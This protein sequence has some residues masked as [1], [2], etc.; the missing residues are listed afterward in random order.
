MKSRVDRCR[1]VLR[2]S[3]SLLLL[4]QRR[5][6]CCRGVCVSDGYVVA[7][8]VACLPFCLGC[9]GM[10]W[11]GGF[12]SDFQ[13]ESIRKPKSDERAASATGRRGGYGWCKKNDDDDGQ[14]DDDDDEWLAG[15]LAGWLAAR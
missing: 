3:S 12:R 15:W 14:D 13:L 2:V 7:V 10:K 9:V 6:L 5:C 1:M 8:A 11:A 4:H